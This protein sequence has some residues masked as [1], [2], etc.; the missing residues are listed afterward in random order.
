MTY[1]SPIHVDDNDDRQL[2]SM[3]CTQNG[4]GELSYFNTPLGVSKGPPKSITNKT[5]TD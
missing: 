4:E 2:T 1:D 5:L 3:S